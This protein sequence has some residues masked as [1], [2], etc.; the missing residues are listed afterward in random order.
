MKKIFLAYASENRV[1]AASVIDGLRTAGHIVFD[2]HNDIPW[3]ANITDEIDRALRE[4]EL[5]VALVTKDFLEMNKSSVAADKVAD[6]LLGKSR[7]GKQGYLM[8][9]CLR[10]GL[11]MYT[12]NKGDVVV[13]AD[14]IVRDI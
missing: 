9:A 5:V 2:L 11:E 3:G 10:V 8:R 6:G 4:C 7:A 12:F 13:S 14:E 1:L